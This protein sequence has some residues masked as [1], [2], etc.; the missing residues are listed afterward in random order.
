[1]DAKE[2]ADDEAAAI[3]YL[4]RVFDL[5]RRGHLADPCPAPAVRRDRLER[6]LAVVRDEVSAIEAAI[7]SDFGGRSGDETLAFEV[8]SCVEEIRHTIRRFPKWM[9]PRRRPVALTSWPGRAEVVKQPLG[10]VGVIV[11]WNYPLY[12]AVSPL[13]G[14]L[15]AGNR[16]IVKMSEHTPRFADLFA[17]RI[18]RAFQEDEVAVVTG[19][20]ETARAFAAKPF[21]HL[22]FTGSTAVGRQIMQA[23]APNL[24]PVTL[25]LGG[26]SPTL[27]A[28]DAALKRIVPRIVFGKLT[29]AGQTCVAP[30]YVLLPRTMEAAF[31]K[32]AKQTVMRFYPGLQ[33]N[34]DYT[35]IV[36]DD[37]AR[38]L[39]SCVDDAKAQGAVVHALHDEPAPEDSRQLIPM[40]FTNV[41]DSMR[42]M[43]EE[44]FGP[45]LPII[46]YDHFD[47]AV[48][49]VNNHAKPL[50]LYLFTQDQARMEQVLRCTVSGGVVINDVMMHV[51][52]N[53][54]PF[55]GVG[56]SGMGH[57]HGP[58]GFD[59]FS[60]LKGVF[61]QSR[62]NGGFLMR[63]PRHRG[64]LRRV[65]TFLLR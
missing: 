41:N 40:A 25:E 46:S 11:P 2:R 32:L 65:A 37:H 33:G 63:P 4:D 17:R 50:A 48:D 34:P 29:N 44:I 30:D 49:Y 28:E 64:R 60:K 36:N 62:I 59:T 27:I 61:R 10:V 42:I 45:L 54:L 20:V 47:E 31:L 13:V 38:R 1:M 18:A 15:A 53:D 35:C 14:A 19:A 7:R 24:T 12:L 3:E 57:Y 26:K 43:R 9:K 23:A 6:L 56:A 39:R 58:E 21:D 51:I 8:L 55:G 52:Q 22:L 5:Q 16:V